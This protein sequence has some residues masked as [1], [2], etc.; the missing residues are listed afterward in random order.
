MGPA[1][2]IVAVL[3]IDYS[4]FIYIQETQVRLRKF[5]N[6]LMIYYSFTFK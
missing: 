3:R 5:R 6:E 1:G 2:Q 4:M